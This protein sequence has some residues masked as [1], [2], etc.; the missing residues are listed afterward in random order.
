MLPSW[1]FILFNLTSD[2]LAMFLGHCF[3]VSCTEPTP[4][5]P[6]GSS[7]KHR[8]WQG[9]HHCH[10]KPSNSCKHDFESH[11]SSAEAHQHSTA[12]T[13]TPSGSSKVEGP[14][15]QKSAWI[16]HR[17]HR[18][19]AEHQDATMTQLVSSNPPLLPGSQPPC[20][21]WLIAMMTIFILTNSHISF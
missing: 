18:S 9:A 1:T 11:D 14:W 15:P 17:H 13:R 2:C 6:E 20:F 10:P 3:C 7:L 21:S 12:A 4:K 19:G 16:Q 5:A 8:Q